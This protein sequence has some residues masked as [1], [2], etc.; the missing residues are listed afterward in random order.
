[1]AGRNENDCPEEQR[2][3]LMEYIYVQS[4][5]ENWK[6]WQVVVRKTILWSDNAAS[7][8]EDLGDS[9]TF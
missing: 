3:R 4:S 8:S 1:V 2:V 5:I 7:D 9:H 6:M